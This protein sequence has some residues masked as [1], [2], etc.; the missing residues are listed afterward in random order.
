MGSRAMRMLG[1]RQ[2]SAR[3]SIGRINEPYRIGDL[4]LSLY[5]CS[6]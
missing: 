4:T 1:S 3:H 6:G 5:A 2:G